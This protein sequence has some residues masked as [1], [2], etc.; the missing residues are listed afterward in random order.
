MPLS[1]SL[2]G[3]DAPRDSEVDVFLP[4]IHLSTIEEEESQV[5][6][7]TIPT[8]KNSFDCGMD[9]SSYT[10]FWDEDE[11]RIHLTNSKKELL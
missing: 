6:I 8:H 4:K 7:T 1:V 3:L 10:L 5:H 2:E 11:D 9:N